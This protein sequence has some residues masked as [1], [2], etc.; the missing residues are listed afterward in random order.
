MS[1]K[2]TWTIGGFVV[3]AIAVSTAYQNCNSG[4]TRMSSVAGT[5]ASVGQQISESKRSVSP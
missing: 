2:K 4:V 1:I 5:V 3:F